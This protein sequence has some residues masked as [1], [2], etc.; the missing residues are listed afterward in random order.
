MDAVD[1]LEATLKEATLKEARQYLWLGVLRI[2]MALKSGTISRARADRC[3]RIHMR[4]WGQIPA[5]T[6][7]MWFVGPEGFRSVIFL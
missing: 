1:R 4:S 7:R 6:Q 5:T 2:A 3:L